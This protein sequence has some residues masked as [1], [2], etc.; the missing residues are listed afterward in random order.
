MYIQ[1][2]VMKLLTN[3][4]INEFHKIPLYKNIYCISAFISVYSFY[5]DPVLAY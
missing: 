2:K 3:F 4:Q 5:T 1:K